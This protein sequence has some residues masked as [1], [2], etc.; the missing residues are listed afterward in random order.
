MPPAIQ[1]LMAALEAQGIRAT[2]PLF[3][4]Y[5]SMDSGLFDFEVGLPVSAPVASMGR[6]R[7]GELPAAKVVRANCRRIA[8][9]TRAGREIQCQSKARSCATRRGR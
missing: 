3:N 5:L 8:D 7:P 4:H 6:V 9:S 2:G 1:E